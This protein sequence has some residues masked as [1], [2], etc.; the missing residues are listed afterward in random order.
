[1]KDK[2]SI[3]V[4]DTVIY[5][6]DTWE[7]KDNFVSATDRYGNGLDLSDLTVSGKV[8]I[9]KIGTYEVTYSLDTAKRESR[10]G[11][12]ELPNSLAAIAEIQVLD[13]KKETPT[14]NSETATSKDNQNVHLGN[15]GTNIRTN[16]LPDAANR[17]VTSNQKKYPQTGEKNSHIPIISGVSMIS[18]ASIIAWFRRKRKRG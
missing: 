15:T 13:N 16:T 1:M 2:S 10:A 12:T 8:N 4:K 9:N 17:T 7:A 5:I 18:V 11:G 14:D 6:G 3:T